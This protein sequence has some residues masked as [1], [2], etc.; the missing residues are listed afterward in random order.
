MYECD[1]YYLLTYLQA[2]DLRWSSCQLVSDNE[3]E[4]SFCL[5]AIDECRDLSVGPTFIVSQQPV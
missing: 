1:T 5:A 2:L 4:R 3:A